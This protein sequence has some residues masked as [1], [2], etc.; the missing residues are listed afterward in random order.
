MAFLDVNRDALPEPGFLIG[1]EKITRHSGEIFEHRYAATG[2]ITYEVPL[3]GEK[4]VDAAIAAARKAFHSWRRTSPAQKRRLMLDY[5]A[6]IRT[7][8]EELRQLTVA[9]NGTPYAATA[10]NTEWTSELWEYNAGWADKIG[11]QVIPTSPGPAFDYTLDE[12]YGVVA[13]IVPWN[14]PFISFS[15]CIAPALASGNTVVIKPPELAPYTCLRLAEIALEVG[16]PPGVINVIPGGPVAGTALT[17]HRGIDKIFFTGSGA[18]ASKIVQASSKYLTPTGFELGGK[19]ARLIFEDADLDKAASAAAYTVAQ[20]SGQACIAATR[21]LVQASIYEEVLERVKATIEAVP[22]GDPRDPGT[23]M[24]PVINQGAVDRITGF[25][26]RAQAEGAGRIL[27]GGGRLGGEYANGYYMAP[28]IFA[29]VSDKSEIA[30]KEIFGPVSAFIKFE[31]E[32]EAVAMANDSDYGLA[33]WVESQNLTRV[34]RVARDLDA[35]T[36]WVNGFF[37]LPVGAPF[38]GV[39]QSGNG[40]LG[41]SYGIQEFT[42]PKNVWLPL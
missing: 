25:I 27:T 17:S 36:V 13:I 5:A 22:I 21:V 1:G 16:F 11:G 3:A 28:T 18:T 2:G 40:R 20:L 6:K 32:E 39:K 8:D 24:G 34:H 19:S 15:Q 14:G 37:D 31:T 23:V 9:E 10:Y 7:M 29:D 38:G 4:E 42:Q 33:A 30:T 35:G 41:G 12:P 26:D